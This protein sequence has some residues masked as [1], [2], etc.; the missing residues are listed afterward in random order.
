[1]T[2]RRKQIMEVG[3]VF[4]ALK[5]RKQYRD[6]QEKYDALAPKAGDLA[7]DFELRDTNGENPV[8][9]SHFRGQKPVALAFG[10]YT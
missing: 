1:M 10:S 5:Y 7:P 9:L 6:W 2:T 4:D 8:R 3:M